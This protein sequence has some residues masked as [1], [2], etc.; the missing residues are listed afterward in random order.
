MSDDFMSEDFGN[1]V[2]EAAPYAPAAYGA[3]KVGSRMAPFAKGAW[4]AGWGA[5]LGSTVARAAGGSTVRSAVGMTA[6]RIAGTTAAR[7]GVAAGVSAATGAAAGAGG[8]AAAGA[9]A[10]SIVPGVGTLAGLAIGALAPL[11]I[12]HTP[13]AGIIRRIPIIGGI[14]SPD[15]KPKTKVI[16]GPGASAPKRNPHFYADAPSHFIEEGSPHTVG[17]GTF[18][19]QNRAEYESGRGFVRR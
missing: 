13:L 10:G 15:G 4:E 7:A 8:G 17:P 19:R 6:A 18:A 12:P 16:G 1:F 11:I 5:E 2:Q 3:Y 14:L 9:A